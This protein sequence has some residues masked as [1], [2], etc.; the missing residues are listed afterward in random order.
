M[1]ILELE[2]DNRIIINHMNYIYE[3]YLDKYII[4]Y[5]K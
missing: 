1:E 5:D 3:I 2:S 4:N